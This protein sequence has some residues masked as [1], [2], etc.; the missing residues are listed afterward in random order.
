MIRPLIRSL[1]LALALIGAGA[2]QA[3]AQDAKPA[4]RP[5]VTV[6]A[7]IVRIGDLVEN[8]G[9]VADVPIFRSPDLGTRGAVATER[10]VEAIRPHHLIGIDTRGLAEIVVTRPSRAITAQEIAARI[11]QALADQ[12]GF[13]KA[14]DIALTFDHAA[15]TLQVEA[16]ATGELQVVE[17]YYDPR[18]GH[19]S[20]AIDLPSSAEL[21]RLAPRFAG[22]AL[23]TIDAVVLAHALERGAVLK[24]SDLTV[25]RRPKAEG[26]FIGDINAAAGLAA[27]YQLRAGQPLHDADLIKPPLVKRNDVVTIVYE[28]PGMVLT[29]RGEAQEAGAL[30]DQISV[31]NVES[32]R[33]MQ[34]IV[35]APGRVSV[36]AAPTRLVDDAPPAASPAPAPEDAQQEHRVSSAE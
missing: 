13:A 20:A 34:G 36:G 29:L 11:A 3:S 28:A 30:G 2:L 5:N 12:Y 22:T 18:N 21:H 15:R 24:A 10:V 27:R 26:P 31:T 35:T 17:L 25:E 8:A 33:V 14:R 23:A 16:D 9:A 1:A 6:A 4:L 32:K 7:D 19:F